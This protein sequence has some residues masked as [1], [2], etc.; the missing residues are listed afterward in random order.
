MLKPRWQPAKTARITT[1]FPRRQHD[2]IGAAKPDKAGV[3]A[4]VEIA[5]GRPYGG[6]Q[7]GLQDTP[8]LRF[9]GMAALGRA[10]G[11]ADPQALL[12][13]GSKLR[14][15]MLVIAFETSICLIAL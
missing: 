4:L 12:D 6:S 3:D 10:D 2:I 11:R 1:R 15:V 13:A 8:G 5:R 9:H 14:I 7:G